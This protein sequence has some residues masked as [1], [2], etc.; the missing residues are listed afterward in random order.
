[1]KDLPYTD[2]VLLDLK[3][4]EAVIFYK[5]S[6]SNDLIDPRDIIDIQIY[7]SKKTEEE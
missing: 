1:M 5:R 4:K 6:S 3:D 7:L 2:I